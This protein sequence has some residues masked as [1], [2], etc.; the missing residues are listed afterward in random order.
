MGRGGPRRSASPDSA[1]ETIG[2][3]EM[4]F[5]TEEPCQA[6]GP[7]WQDKGHRGHLQGFFGHKCDALTL[8]I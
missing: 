5:E 1:P 8:N 6:E 2:R 7:S 4:V 3:F